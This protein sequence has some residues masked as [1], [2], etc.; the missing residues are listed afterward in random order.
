MLQSWGQFLPA[1]LPL[2]PTKPLATADGEW[3]HRTPAREGWKGEAGDGSGAGPR[4]SR[5]LHHMSDHACRLNLAPGLDQRS[6]V[7]PDHDVGS[8]D[9]RDESR[10]CRDPALGD[11]QPIPIEHRHFVIHSHSLKEADV[12]EDL[13]HIRG[14]Y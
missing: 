2:P 6:R 3:R 1:A 14:L 8:S 4:Q 7:V 10:L 13:N 11:A 12:S 5:G 9:K